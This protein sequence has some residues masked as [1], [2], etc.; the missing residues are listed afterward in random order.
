M[1][2]SNRPRKSRKAEKPKEFVQ[3]NDLLR[4]YRLALTYRMADLRLSPLRTQLKSANCSFPKK[5][6]TS[7]SAFVSDR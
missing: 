1:S 3:N 6:A 7:K 5:Q 4:I 2:G